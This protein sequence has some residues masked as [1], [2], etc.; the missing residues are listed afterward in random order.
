M[1]TLDMLH[2]TYS[3]LSANK[4]RTG[5]TMLGIIIGIS[6]VIAMVSIGQGAQKTIESNIQSIGANLIMVSPGAQ[7]TAAEA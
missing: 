5:L 3:A 4:V 1:N 2:E 7:Q 6:S